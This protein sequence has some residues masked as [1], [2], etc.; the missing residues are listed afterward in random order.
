[1][2]SHPPVRITLYDWIADAL[3]WVV[4]RLDALTCRLNSRRNAI[5]VAWWDA[6]PDKSEGPF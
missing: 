5:A 3:G 2:A 4:V 6:R 1:M